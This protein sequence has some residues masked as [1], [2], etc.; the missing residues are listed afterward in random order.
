[1]IVLE[2]LSKVFQA[3]TPNENPAIRNINL[4]INEG[5]FITIIG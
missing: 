1:M 2:N 3:G 4:S 5:D